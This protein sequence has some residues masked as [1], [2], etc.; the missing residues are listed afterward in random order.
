MNSDEFNHLLGIKEIGPELLEKIDACD[1]HSK[2]SFDKVIRSIQL[3]KV[4]LDCFH[5]LCSTDKKDVDSLMA[6]YE[7]TPPQYHIYRSDVG[8]LYLIDTQGYNYCRY[9]MKVEVVDGN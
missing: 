5:I 9:A 2:S 8:D 3:T 4:E 1:W 7:K 6:V